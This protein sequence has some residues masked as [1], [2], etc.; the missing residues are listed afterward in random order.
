MSFSLYKQFGAKLKMLLLSEESISGPNGRLICIFFNVCP[1]HQLLFSPYF[2]NSDR[3]L[4]KFI[5][6]QFWCPVMQYCLKLFFFFFYFL[7][8]RGEDFKKPFDFFESRTDVSV[9]QDDLRRL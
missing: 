1:E 4:V 6:G 3:I 9:I 2:S 8:Q 7:P 5:S